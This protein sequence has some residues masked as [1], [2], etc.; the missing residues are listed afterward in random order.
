MRTAVIALAAVVAGLAF[1]QSA[2][3]LPPKLSGRYNFVGP[4]GVYNDAVTLTFDAPAVAGKVSG[5][6]SW[7]GVNCGALD[8]PFVGTWDGTELRIE[9]THRA[10]VNTQ[11]PNG[12]CGSGR[13]TYTLKRMPGSKF[14]G[15]VQIE[16]S[17]AIATLALAP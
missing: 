5:R 13:A 16:G 11:R 12:Q 10:N 2:D 9:T 1:A 4:Q 17:P 7:R 14:E 3:P 15:Q 8:E 6:V